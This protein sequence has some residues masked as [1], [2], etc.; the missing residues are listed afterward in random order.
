MK[1]L[2]VLA[3][4]LL[5]LAAGVQAEVSATFTET[6]VAADTGDVRTDTFYTEWFPMYNVEHIQFHVVFDED[7]SW[8]DDDSWV[9][10]LQQSY[11]KNTIVSSTLSDT[12][13]ED[14]D[15][16]LTLQLD[17]S[18]D[19]VIY[20]W[21]RW[22]CIHADSIGVDEADSATVGATY[23]NTLFVYYMFTQ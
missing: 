18:D 16:A 7:T 12:L 15:A 10:L 1:R 3:T 20:H 2:L 9:L 8:G 13:T 14:A 6:I 19:D 23:T 17:R 5:L 11:N 4:V 21:G 22:A